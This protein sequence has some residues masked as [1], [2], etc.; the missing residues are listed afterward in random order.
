MRVIEHS[1][2][3]T[4]FN[5][6]AAT[7]CFRHARFVIHEHVANQLRCNRAASCFVPDVGPSL[8]HGVKRWPSPKHSHTSFPP[9]KRT[10]FRLEAVAVRP[11]AGTKSAG[12]AAGRTPESP[13]DRMGRALEVARD[14]FLISRAP[15]RVLVG[16]DVCA[17]DA[18]SLQRMGLLSG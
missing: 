12:A 2:P 4:S 9:C 18:I 8:Q 17:P 1:C 10:A 5:A 7:P 3:S 16:E 13:A 14:R 6:Q 15:G 11:I